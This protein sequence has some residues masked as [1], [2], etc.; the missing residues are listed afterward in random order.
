MR[1]LF[2]TTVAASAALL[3]ACANAG[4]DIVEPQYLTGS[5]HVHTSL[6]TD[7]DSIF[8]QTDTKI[9]GVK[10]FIFSA[11]GTD[12]LRT[13]VTGVDGRAPSTG[14]PLGS[15][16]YA[17]DHSMLGDSVTL[18]VMDSGPIRLLARLDSIGDLRQVL[19]TYPHLTTAQIREL[20]A[21]RRVVLKAKILAPPQSFHLE[22]AFVADTSGALRMPR[23]TVVG[24][25]TLAIGDSVRILGLTGLLDGQ[26]VLK[27]A[28]ITS[29]GARPIPI[30]RTTTV[31]EARTAGGGS[32]DARLVQVSGIEISD[33]MVVDPD[34]HVTVTSVL[35]PEETLTVV[36][37]QRFDVV[38]SLYRPGRNIVVRGV[39]TPKGD[40]TWVLRPRSS[41][42][43]TFPG[44]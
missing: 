9:A 2:T 35:D 14:L 18:A 11:H 23:P 22:D 7:G 44:P 12:T 32:L 26:V 39:L 20:P 3:T 36:I 34:F 40:G 6:D 30:V 16:R 15:Y 13:V 8:S 42:D 29:L 4:K 10:V 38:H 25:G 17:I 21:D 31:A 19:F 41:A 33:T 27:E 37:D 28:K 1:R 5:F 43:I 24:D